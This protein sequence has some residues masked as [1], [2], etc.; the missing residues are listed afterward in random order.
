MI[1]PLPTTRP[2]THPPPLVVCH[3]IGMFPREDGFHGWNCA[4]SLDLSDTGKR[5]FLF[6]NGYIMFRKES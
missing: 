6:Y 3:H 4:A 2:F 1:N 5:G